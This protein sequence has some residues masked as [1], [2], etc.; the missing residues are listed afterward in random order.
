MAANDNSAPMP[1]LEVL[2]RSSVLKGELEA[3]AAQADPRSAAVL[4]YAAR[5]L[6]LIAGQNHAPLPE[7][8]PQR[9]NRP[10]SLR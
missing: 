5:V 3:L 6:R 10:R 8:R 7:F 2:L 9:V 4:E 1:G